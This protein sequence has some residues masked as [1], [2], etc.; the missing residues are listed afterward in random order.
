MEASAYLQGLS[1]PSDIVSEP[2]CQAI[3][4]LAPLLKGFDTAENIF[5]LDLTEA[6][7]LTADFSFDITQ[8]RAAAFKAAEA[9]AK[10]DSPA[11]K[12]AAE[13]F[14][15]WN[16]E[17]AQT[18]QNIADIWFEFDYSECE[19]GKANPCLFIDA[20]RVAQ[21]QSNLWLYEETL[22]VLLGGAVPPA[23]QEHLD[24]CIQALPQ[25]EVLFQLGVMLARQQQEKKVRLFTGEMN[26]I[27]FTDY[28]RQA[29]V[30]TPLPEALLPLMRTHS[31]GKYIVDFDISKSGLSAKMGINFGLSSYEPQGLSAFLKA[32]CELNL[33]DWRRCAPLLSW[34]GGARDISHFKLVLDPPK[35]V[36]AKVYLREWPQ[37]ASDNMSRW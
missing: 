1:L 15:L 7:L 31:D 32:L 26:I 12:A 8:E 23:L 3:R 25:G 20:M 2:A 34:C 19:S 13:V 18:Y 10:A 36:K 5:E 30:S 17:H 21:G 6:S 28:L 37:K 4:G 29:E 16:N 35:P 33:A 24:R 9:L 14:A 11:W 22:P 27:R